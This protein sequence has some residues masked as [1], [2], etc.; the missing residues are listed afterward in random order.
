MAFYEKDILD[1]VY[2]LANTI[3]VNQSREVLVILVG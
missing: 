1:K 2:E 3:Y